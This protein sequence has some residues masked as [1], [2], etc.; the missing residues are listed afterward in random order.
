MAGLTYCSHHLQASVISGLNSVCLKSLEASH[1]LGQQ[2]LLQAIE[3]RLDQL[4]EQPKLIQGQY[5]Q[6][7][8]LTH[9]YTEFMGFDIKLSNGSVRDA[10]KSILEMERI[11]DELGGLPDL[12]DVGDLKNMI[13][14][15][16][17]TL[18][19][20]LVHFLQTLFSATYRISKSHNSV[21]ELS[22][23]NRVTTALGINYMHIP[24]PVEDMLDA[25]EDLDVLVPQLKRLNQALVDHFVKPLKGATDA[26][27]RVVS[28]HLAHTLQYARSIRNAEQKNE[29][30]SHILQSLQ[31]IAVFVRDHVLRGHY[32]EEYEQLW[33]PG[34]IAFVRDICLRSPIIQDCLES[35]TDDGSGLRTEV[36]KFDREL[37]EM[38]MLSHSRT[39]LQSLVGNIPVVRMKSNR[40]KL[41]ATVRD[42]LRQSDNLTAE[43]CEATERGGLK[44]A[45]GSGK[46]ASSQPVKEK[47]G[48]SQVYKEVSSTFDLKKCRIS[49]QVQTLVEMIYLLM[50]QACKTKDLIESKEKICCIRDIVSMFI[51]CTPVYH[52]DDIYNIPS[53]AMLFYNDCEY[54]CHH[55]LFLGPSFSREIQEELR[56]LVLFVD[57]IHQ[58]RKLSETHF[59]VHL[60][61]QRDILLHKL[62]LAQGFRLDS[63]DE[64]TLTTCESAVRDTLYQLDQIARAWKP[65]AQQ[66]MLHRAL[67]LLVDQVLASL[68]EQVEL[69]EPGVGD[70]SS[71]CAMEMSFEASPTRH[72]LKHLVQRFRVVEKYFD[73][74]D[75]KHTGLGAGG[76]KTQSGISDFVPS[77]PAFLTMCERLDQLIYSVSS[78]KRGTLF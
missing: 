7:S 13:E 70:L 34:V 64:A 9:I 73:V 41:L 54:L 42:I 61:K 30:I 32:I 33:A 20:S 51:A 12:L 55:L 27:I 25:M 52:G 39:D 26:D 36:L 31:K 59:R 37:K 22:V 44:S 10:S 18:K 28:T 45:H 78:S 5:S 29:D 4:D 8:L 35:G 21:W 1:V 72:Q 63:D 56:H 77:W 60:R 40:T 19:S 75:T 2:E 76:K 50:D 14:E 68:S 69:I 74:E 53:R 38:N 16:Y 58:L 62:G 71:G 57:Y 47:R 66:D 23:A 6:L 17:L 67:G 15:H 46:K 11:V 65:I 49:T 3:D 24:V 48:D 43:V